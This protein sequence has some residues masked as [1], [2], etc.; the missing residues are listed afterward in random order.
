[1]VNSPGSTTKP[2][3]VR[4]LHQWCL[5]FK[6]TPYLALVVCPS[7]RVPSDY[8]TN[9]EIVLNISP[10]AA[11]NLTVS[12]MDLS[13]VGRFSGKPMDV[14]VPIKN[15]FAIYA[16]ETGEGIRFDRMIY[17]ESESTSRSTEAIK[18]LGITREDKPDLVVVRRDKVDGNKE[19]KKELPKR[20]RGK[21]KSHLKRIK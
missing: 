4:A 17:K 12:E 6:Y 21:L 19:G 20:G 13:F 15:V 5:D 16:K 3:L 14:W 2:Y 8:V 1:M 11:Y 18:T 7:T 10:N 9:G